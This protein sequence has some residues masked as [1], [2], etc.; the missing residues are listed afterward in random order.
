MI[1]H[2][3]MRITAKSSK[4]ISIECQ[5]RYRLWPRTYTDNEMMDV[6]SIILVGIATASLVV[7]GFEPLRSCGQA[8]YS[9]INGAWNRQRLAID[10]AAGFRSRLADLS[11]GCSTF[12]PCG[13]MSVPCISAMAVLWN[14]WVSNCSW[15]L[16]MPFWR[17]SFLLNKPWPYNPK[18]HVNKN[19]ILTGKV[20]KKHV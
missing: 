5:E 4:Q 2:K 6:I 15:S 10:K 20:R 19:N 14:G 8:G 13:A 17:L 9:R 11:S 18:R 1:E 12:P 7:H 16:D 3:Q